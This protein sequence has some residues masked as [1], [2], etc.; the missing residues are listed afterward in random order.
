M[1]HLH[2]KMKKGRPY[3]YIREIQRVGGKPK[4][5]S[6]IYLGSVD[7]IAKR[8]QPAEQAQIPG[9]EPVEARLP[10]GHQRPHRGLEGPIRVAG[11]PLGL[12]QQGGQ[13]VAELLA[14]VGQVAVVEHEPHVVLDH[15]QP[16]AGPVGRRVQDP[17]WA[18]GQVA[19]QTAA[20]PVSP[21]VSVDADLTVSSD[22]VFERITAEELWACTTCRACDQACPVGLEIVDKIL[23]MRRYLSLMEAE[24][25]SELGKAYVSLENSSNIYGMDQTTRGDWVKE[26]DFEVKVLG[27][28]GVTAEYLYWVGCAGSFDDRNR[29]VTISTAKLLNRAGVDFAILGK[30]ELCTGDPARRTGNEYVFQGLALQNIETLNDLGVTKIVTQCPHCFNT[31]KNEYPQFGGEYETIHHSELLMRLV[32]EG[33]ITP[34][35]NGQTVTFHDPCY[36]GRYNDGY[37]PPRDVIDSVGERVEMARSTTGAFCCGAEAGMSA[38]RSMSPRSASVRASP[39]VCPREGSCAAA[40][41]ADAA[42]ALHDL[43][44]DPQ[45]MDPGQRLCLGDWCLARGAELAAGIVGAIGKDPVQDKVVMQEYLET[46]VKE[47][48]G[49]SDLY[50]ACREIDA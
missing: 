18:L 31:L 42:A 6:Q 37:T 40:G 8:I 10:G 49:W 33:K 1:A 46:V 14:Q 47:R 30:N 3:Y 2:K 24:F 13:V 21:P 28:P 7:T 22:L 4:V 50:R 17:Q 34:D 29:K 43:L 5:V 44:T 15:P 11:P 19:A 12:P 32:E 35:S 48:K 41:D 23:D 27:E 20:D 38:G 9:D 36:L 25:P 16:L 26:L 45:N 39:P